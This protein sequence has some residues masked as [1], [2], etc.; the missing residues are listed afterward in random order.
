MLVS[1]TLLGRHE[2]ESGKTVYTKVMRKMAF[3]YHAYVVQSIREGKHPSH[4]FGILHRKWVLMMIREGHSELDILLAVHS[5]LAVLWRSMEVCC[6]LKKSW[7]LAVH[8][9]QVDH[10]GEILAG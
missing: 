4:L 8:S 10:Q 6:C 2:I 7:A 5:L 9:I 3:I 1:R